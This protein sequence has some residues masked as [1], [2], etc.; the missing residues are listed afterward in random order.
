MP[1]SE[2]A[3]R[4]SSLASRRLRDNKQLL[5]GTGIWPRM[6]WTRA[7]R[8]GVGHMNAN[9]PSTLGQGRRSQ[10]LHFGHGRNAS[11]ESCSKFS[12]FNLSG[13]RSYL[14]SMPGHHASDILESGTTGLKHMELFFSQSLMKLHQKFMLL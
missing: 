9:L 12:V 5:Y 14:S 8:I 13:S 4:A 6:R 2:H 10:I 7:Y 11:D 3:H 1:S